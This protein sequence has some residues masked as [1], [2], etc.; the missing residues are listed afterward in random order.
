MR[1]KVNF[2]SPT[3]QVWRAGFKVQVLWVPQGE[4]SPGLPLSAGVRQ[5]GLGM[6]LGHSSGT[7]PP[8]PFC[9]LPSDHSQDALGRLALATPGEPGLWSQLPLRPLP[10]PGSDPPLGKM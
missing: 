5:H 2:L 6:A 9:A 3:R 10:S 4:R 1:S 8:L 7:L